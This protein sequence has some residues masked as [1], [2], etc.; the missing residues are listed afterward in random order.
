MDLGHLAENYHGIHPASPQAGYERLLWREC[1]PRADRVRVRNHTCECQ[2]VVYEL[3]Q[4]G[5]L[6]FVRRIYRS[7]GVIEHQ[8][9]WL[10]APEA[11]RLWTRILLGQAR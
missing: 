9:T 3:C 6:S 7:D 5:G 11:E 4:A 1:A 8:T 10:R 2:N